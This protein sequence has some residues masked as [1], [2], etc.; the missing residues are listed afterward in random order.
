MKELRANKA[1]AKPIRVTLHGGSPANEVDIDHSQ[2]EDKNMKKKTGGF[3]AFFKQAKDDAP[4]S[5]FIEITATP[6]QKLN[7]LDKLSYHY[8]PNHL[9]VSSTLLHFVFAA[10][11]HIMGCLSENLQP[12]ND[13]VV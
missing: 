12:Q 3:A 1:D 11:T 7:L 8:M 2:V 10:Q 9:I 13:F 5:F 4:T 6:L